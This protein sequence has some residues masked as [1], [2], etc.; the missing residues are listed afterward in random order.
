MTAALCECGVVAYGRCS[1]CNSAYCRSHGDVGNYF[2]NTARSHCLACGTKARAERQAQLDAAQ[3]AVNERVAHAKERITLSASA[4]AKRVHPRPRVREFTHLDFHDNK[5]LKP[6]WPVGKFNWSQT[7]ARC[8]VLDP[9][10]A[11]ETGVTAEG[12]IVPM[13][14]ASLDELPRG[15]EAR[16]RP[17]HLHHPGAEEYEQIAQALAAHLAKPD[18]APENQQPPLSG[19]GRLWRLFSKQ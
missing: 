6:A 7:Y 11:Q 17:R 13:M 3:H 1:T 8:D 15:S 10:V 4:L 14:E 2:D 19:V 12:I 16:Y 18:V 5:R 9:F